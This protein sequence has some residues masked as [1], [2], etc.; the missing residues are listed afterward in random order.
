MQALNGIGPPGLRGLTSIVAD[1]NIDSRRRITAINQLPRSAATNGDFVVTCLTIAIQDKDPNV[2]AVATHVLGL[3][4]SAPEISV[5]A[6]AK[7]YESPHASVRVRAVSALAEF[8]LHASTATNVLNRALSDPDLRI[9]EAAR[10]ALE[11][12]TAQ[13]PAASLQ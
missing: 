7:A 4:H 10:V 9:Q 1:T 5:P 12:V 3:L 8:G 13:R 2:A 6:I 11:R